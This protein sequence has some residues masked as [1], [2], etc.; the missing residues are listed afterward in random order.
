MAL[1][2]ETVDACQTMADCDV[3]IDALIAERA[4]VIDRMLEITSILQDLNKQRAAAQTQGTSALIALA[5][6][7]ASVDAL[8]T[9]V[10]KP[11][12]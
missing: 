8:A 2:K 1:D 6:V 12:T 10:A 9:A 7:T 5:G 3:R 4:S 11:L